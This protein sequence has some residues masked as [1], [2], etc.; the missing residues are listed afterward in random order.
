VKN[1]ESG[2]Y[3]DGRGLW[4]VKSSKKTG[5][6]VLRYSIGGRRREMGLGSIYDTSLKEARVAAYKWR[7]MLKEGLDPIRERDRLIREASS[8]KPLLGDVAEACF[9]ARKAQ[10]K[11]EGKN[12]Q[13]FAPLELHVLPYIGRLEIEDVD[14]NDIK[15]VL[16]PIWHKKAETARKAAGRLNIVMKHGAAMG[17]DVDMQAVAK[18]KALLGA[19]RHKVRHIPAM[20][21][22]EVPEFYASLQNGGMASNA[23]Q[24]LILTLA[25]TSEIRKAEWKEFEG[26]IWTIPAEK[27]KTGKEHRVPIT[28]E[29][30]KLLEVI[31]PYSQNGLLF[32]SRSR[33]PMTDMAMSALMRRR[34]LDYRPHGFRS[35]FRDWVAEAT[36][37]PKEVAE[38]CLAHT[39]GSKV[40][41]SYR[42]TD[43]LDKRRKLMEKWA[44][45]IIS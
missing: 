23:L 8:V 15:R 39:V 26:D 41:L 17:L 45:H 1:N 33:T 2:K 31:R 19:H 16:S 42:R 7:G 43:Y 38:A 24:L 40:E 12:G 4:L 30:L 6:W 18:A 3:C 25:R 5:K 37:T 29:A 28:D 27:T 14:Q 22:K 36:D 13:W 20:P 10:L 35:S 11:G 9:E 21:W 32:P 44:G 34:K